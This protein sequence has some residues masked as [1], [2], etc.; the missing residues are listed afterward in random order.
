MADKKEREP[1]DEQD[2]RLI[3]RLVMFHAVCSGLTA[4]ERKRIRNPEPT[5]AEEGFPLLIDSLV[6][7]ANVLG[8][9]FFEASKP[10]LEGE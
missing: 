7:T 8:D 4:E 3:S 1:M 5:S 10:L 2:L 6:E 9:R